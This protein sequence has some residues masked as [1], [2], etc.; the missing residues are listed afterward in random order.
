M[1]GAVLNGKTLIIQ[2]DGSEEKS[3]NLIESARYILHGMIHEVAGLRSQYNVL[4]I[5]HLSFSSG[6]YIGY[7]CQPW[8]WVH[9]DT[10]SPQHGLQ[11]MMIKL[12]RGR[13]IYE[14]VK[15]EVEEQNGVI[16]LTALIESIVPKA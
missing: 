6:H 3:R 8:R 11:P 14:I 7:P 12:M 4:L 15:S 2:I 5:I 13:S 10:I 1:K 16:P 9:I